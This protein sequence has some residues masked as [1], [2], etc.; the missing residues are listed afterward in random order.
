MC[1]IS[2]NDWPYGK[3][4]G[5]IDYN[6]KHGINDWVE[7]TEAVYWEQLGCVPPVKSMK[8]CFMVGE[9]YT[10][11]FYSVFIEVDNRFFGKLCRIKTF[12]PYIY[13]AEVLKHIYPKQDK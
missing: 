5:K 12:D 13:R 6:F 2:K 9:C 11:D 4:P 1:E 10:Q 7:T 3:E 8:G